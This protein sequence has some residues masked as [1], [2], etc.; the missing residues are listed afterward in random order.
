MRQSFAIGGINIHRDAPPFVIAEM[1]CNHNG[2]LDR[3]LRLIDLAARSGAHA[4]K[5]QTYTAETMTIRC[6]KPDFRISGGLWDG[7]ELYQLYEQAHTPWEWHPEL[8]ARARERGILAF[9][10]PFDESAVDFLEQFDPPAYKIASFE[11]NDHRLIR[12]AVATGKPLLIST[13]M[14]PVDEVFGVVD[15]VSREGGEKLALMHCVSSYP[16]PVESA[17]ICTVADMAKRFDIPIGLSDHTLSTA[18]ALSAVAMGA[19]LL[20]KHFTIQRD[21]GGLD[22]AFS[23]QPEELADLCNSVKEVR[24]V[25]GSVCYG[26]NS[27]S[28]NN[29]RF[30]RSLYA[31]EDIAKGESLSDKNI[32]AI[33]PGHGLPPQDYDKVIGKRAKKD[34]EKGTPLSW[35]LITE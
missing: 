1:S 2:S 13:G 25:L 11:A 7:Y 33:R 23:I 24:S 6:D 3:A 5:F 17:N 20:E 27:A 21:D 10:T 14:L 35:A 30:R 9:S 26:P 15:L 34:I 22:A 28:E 19:S 16:T 4:I 32:R 18:T 12:K 31:T 29:V 8:F